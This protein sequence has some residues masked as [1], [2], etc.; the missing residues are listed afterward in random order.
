M[1]LDIL[2]TS[3]KS[4]C[5]QADDVNVTEMLAMSTS[6]IN[7]AS[8][9]YDVMSILYDYCDADNIEKDITIEREYDFMY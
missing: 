4:H 9:W 6:K 3:S 5:G 8:V 1:K 7:I 2:S